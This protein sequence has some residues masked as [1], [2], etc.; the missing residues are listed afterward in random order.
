MESSARVEAERSSCP[1]AEEEDRGH[2]RCEAG[3]KEDIL[4]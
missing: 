2:G 3:G 4:T 1:L